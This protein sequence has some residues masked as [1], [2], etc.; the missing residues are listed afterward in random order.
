MADRI[1]FFLDQHQSNALA[2]GLRA[3]GIDVLTAHE[4]GRCGL[5]DA[6]QLAFATAEGRVIVT[7]DTDFLTLHGAGVSHARIA[8]C[9]ATKYPVGQ[10]IDTLVLVH[11]VLTADEMVNNVEYL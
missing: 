1:R 2:A 9:P 3:P 10:L 6:D 4:A 11:G 5:P 8:W 7:F